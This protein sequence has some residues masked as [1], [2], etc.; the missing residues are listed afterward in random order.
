ML[1]QHGACDIEDAEPEVTCEA[2]VRRCL[3]LRIGVVVYPLAQVRDRHVVIFFFFQAEDGIRDL[4]VWSSDVCSSDLLADAGIGYVHLPAL[5]NPQDNRAAFRR[6]SPAARERYR[7]EVLASPGGQRALV[8]IADLAE[9]RSE[10]RRV[11]EE[12]RSR[13]APD[14]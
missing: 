4:T 14:H 12:G 10:E 8:T 3:N 2:Q 13:W 9:Q 6:G 5:G 7:Q 1:R 11:G